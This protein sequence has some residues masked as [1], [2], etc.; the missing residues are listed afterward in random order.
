MT[1]FTLILGLLT[2]CNFFN[3][4]LYLYYQTTHLLN[5]SCFSARLMRWVVGSS[6]RCPF[7]LSDLPGWLGFLNSKPSSFN[8]NTFTLYFFNQILANYF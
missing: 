5:S 4:H 3:L 7:L 8:Y 6:H 1:D 2:P